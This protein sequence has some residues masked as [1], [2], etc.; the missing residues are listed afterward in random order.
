LKGQKQRV[1]RFKVEILGNLQSGHG[2]LGF[3]SLGKMRARLKKPE[4]K[5]KKLKKKLQDF[6]R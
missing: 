1:E 2:V 5:F 3:D 6:K 4:E